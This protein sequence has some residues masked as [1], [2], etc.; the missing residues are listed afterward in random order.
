MAVDERN[1]FPSRECNERS[2]A[3]AAA[4]GGREESFPAVEGRRDGGGGRRGSVKGDGRIRT[5]HMFWF[6]FGFFPS[7]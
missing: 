5:G 2:R 4:A 6:C 7:V 3:A 1:R